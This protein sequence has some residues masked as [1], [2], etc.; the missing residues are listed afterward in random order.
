MANLMEDGGGGIEE[1]D[2]AS[3]RLLEDPGGLF[4]PNQRKTLIAR[5]VGTRHLIRN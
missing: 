4:G 2:R 3:H 5:V 1:V